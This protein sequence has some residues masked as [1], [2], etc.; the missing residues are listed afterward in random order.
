MQE[1]LD[2]SRNRYVSLYDVAIVY[3]ALGDVESALTSLEHARELSFVV[4]DPA[5]DALRSELRFQQIVVRVVR[6]NPS[7]DSGLALD[8]LAVYHSGQPR[9]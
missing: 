6:G 2:L 3:A 1:L 8:N 5:F 4:V 9:S 7:R